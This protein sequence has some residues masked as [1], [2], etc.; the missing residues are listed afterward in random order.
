MQEANLL[1]LRVSDRDILEVIWKTDV[2]PPLK[3]TGS[4]HRDIGIYTI[5]ILD[6][7]ALELL[8][9]ASRKSGLNYG[10]HGFA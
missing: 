9:F 7:R 10:C 8:S 1:K 6:K 5:L 2:S 3:D 4:T